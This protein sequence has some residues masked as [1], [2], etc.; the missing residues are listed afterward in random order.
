MPYRIP[1]E[2]G[3]DSEENVKWMEH[4]V[5]SVMNTGKDKTTAIKIC[6]AKFIEKKNKKASKLNTYK[7]QEK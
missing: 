3:G 7:K 5:S 4:C 2:Y 1:R 6:K